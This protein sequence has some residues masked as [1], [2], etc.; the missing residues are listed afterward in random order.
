[1][2][3]RNAA[4]DQRIDSLVERINKMHKTIMGQQLELGD[5]RNRIRLLE[6]AANADRNRAGPSPHQGANPPG[7]RDHT[8]SV[9]DRMHELL[10]VQMGQPDLAREFGLVARQK[11]LND[12]AARE[13]GTEWE[14]PGDDYESV[15]EY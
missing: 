7:G 5:L 11:E 13:A 4:R 9:A 6:Q 8:M 12:S 10:L 2:F 14:E 3:G 15:Y 1:M